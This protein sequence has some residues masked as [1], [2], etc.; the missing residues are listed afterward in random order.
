[1][2]YRLGRRE[3][4]NGHATPG[5]SRRDQSYRSVRLLP[6]SEHL[7]LLLTSSLCT[8]TPRLLLS[9]QYLSSYLQLHSSPPLR[10]PWPGSSPGLPLQQGSSPSSPQPLA[11]PADSLCM[12]QLTT[13]VWLSCL[14]SGRPSQHIQSPSLDLGRPYPVTQP[15]RRAS[16]QRRELALDQR[17]LSR[18]SSPT[19]LETSYCNHREPLQANL[20]PTL[21]PSHWYPLHRGQE[22]PPNSPT[23]PPA[24]LFPEASL[25]PFRTP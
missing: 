21:L 13:H 6:V 7:L 2:T 12:A 3:C 10:L 18:F 5:T 4:R 20:A 24:P 11:R 9:V 23:L 1:M 16:P 22:Y 25:L 19:S 17:T 8:C 15:D 14:Y